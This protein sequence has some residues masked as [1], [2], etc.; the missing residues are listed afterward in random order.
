MPFNFAALNSATKYPSIDTYHRLDPADGTL[1]PDQPPMQFTGPVLLTEK[2]DGTGARII[3]MPDGDFFIGSR[4]ELLYA[5][6]DRIPNPALGIVAELRA[7]A[8]ALPVLLGSDQITVFYLE[9]YGHRIGGGWKQYTTGNVFG[10]RMF[11]MATIPIEA[12]DWPVEQIASWRQ[13][14]GQQWATEEQLVRVAGDRVQLTP[15]LG[16][17]DGTGLPVTTWETLTMLRQRAPFTHVALDATGMGR[18]EG[19]VLRNENR[20]TIAKAKLRDYER[21]MEKYAECP[22]WHYLPGPQQDD[23]ERTECPYRRRHADM[24]KA[25]NARTQP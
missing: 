1:L 5:C 8:A 2:V 4:E 21:T 3:V 7:L 22:P 11:D 24:R 25:Y 16:V 20:S 13:H 18:A 19:I 6:G 10:H 17:I 15:R 23:P 14:G 9:V 12:L